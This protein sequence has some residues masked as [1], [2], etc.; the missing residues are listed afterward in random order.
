MNDPKMVDAISRSNAISRS[1]ALA[2]MDEYID[3]ARD[4]EMHHAM[5]VV[6]EGLVEL[7]ALDVAPVVHAR[8]KFVRDKDCPWITNAVCGACKTKN[9]SRSELSST[10]LQNRYSESHKYCFVCGARMDGEEE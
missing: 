6:A 4:D 8:W 10:H 5:C 7:P 2:M 9:L 1:A 3:M